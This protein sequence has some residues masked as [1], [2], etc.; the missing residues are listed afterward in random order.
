MASPT[1]CF[2]YLREKADYLYKEG[3]IEGTASYR[4]AGAVMLIHKVVESIANQPSAQTLFE[5][6]ARTPAPSLEQLAAYMVGDSMLYSFTR[7]L[8]QLLEEVLR[9]GN[10]LVD[11]S[12]EGFHPVGHLS[13]MALRWNESLAC[14]TLPV[15]RKA[16]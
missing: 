5:R 2:T 4:D 9:E 14:A 12:R 10:G 6:L 13:F 16:V 11:G 15:A 3:V 1:R 8:H 7:Q